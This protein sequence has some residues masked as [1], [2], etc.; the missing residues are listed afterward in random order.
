MR[1]LSTLFSLG[2]L[3]LAAAQTFENNVIY[4]PEANYTDP[5]V[6]YARAVQLSDGTLLSTWENYSPEPPLVSFP[7]YRSAD[8]GE[9][10]AEI[11]RVRDEVNG[12]GMCYQPELYQLPEAVGEFDAGTVLCAGNSIP[13]DLSR[14]KIDVYASRDLGVT[15]EFVSSVAE[16][17]EALPNPGLTPVW[18]P[19]FMMYDG[20]LVLYYSDQRDNETYSQKLVHQTTTDLKNWDDLVDDVTHDDYYQRPGMPTVAQLPTGDYIY[21]YEFGGEASQDDYW[22]PVYYR[23]SAD[24]LAFASAPDQALRPNN[25][26]TTVPQGSPYV[27]WSPYGGENGT[28]VVSCGTLGQVFTNQML[29]HPDHWVM[30]ETPQPTAYT[31]FV[32]IKDEDPDLLLIMGAGVLPPS[33]TNKV[34]LSVVRLSELGVE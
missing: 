15:W 8:G 21:V 31:R 25:D 11:S 19:W 10:W 2:G 33:T 13:T 3:S 7:I 24:P 4:V 23:I 29:G 20:Q 30:R 6:L 18:E 26:D 5:R 14:T 27:T 32:M 22:F 28:I 9:T 1:L 12:W 16:G 34:S 17:G